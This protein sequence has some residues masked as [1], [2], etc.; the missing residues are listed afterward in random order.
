MDCRT[1]PSEGLKHMFV[2]I[3]QEKR[4]DTGERLAFHKMHGAALGVLRMRRDIAEDLRVGE[5]A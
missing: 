5:L 3:V 2:D 1:Q 4:I